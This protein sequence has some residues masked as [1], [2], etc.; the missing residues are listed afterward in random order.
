MHP[1]CM[2]CVLAIRNITPPLSTKVDINVIHV[3]RSPGPFPTVFAYYNR[4]VLKDWEQAY[5]LNTTIST[6][7]YMHLNKGNGSSILSIWLHIL[8][9]SNVTAG[10]TQLNTI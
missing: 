1:T 3:I 9:D 7:V 2:K 5:H 10:G 6:Y 8:L 4:T